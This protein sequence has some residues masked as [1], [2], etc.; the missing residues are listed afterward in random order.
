MNALIRIMVFNGIKSRFPNFKDILIYL[1]EKRAVIRYDDDRTQN[2]GIG[3]TEEK[4]VSM[5]AE[6]KEMKRVDT[7]FISQE[8]NCILLRGDKDVIL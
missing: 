3:T 7:I 8:K 6:S 1:N 4:Y 2:I 5:L